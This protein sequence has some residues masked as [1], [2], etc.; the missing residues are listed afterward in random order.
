M[1][2]LLILCIKVWL[3][4]RHVAIF[5]L[6]INKLGFRMGGK[7]LPY[8]VIVLGDELRVSIDPRDGRISWKIVGT[9]SLQN[10]AIIWEIIH[11]NGVLVNVSPVQNEQGVLVFLVNPVQVF[12]LRKI[13]FG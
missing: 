9:R 1:R 13:A 4:Y 3:K 5:N 2:K 8:V 12:N 11:G 6:E 10:F 7:E